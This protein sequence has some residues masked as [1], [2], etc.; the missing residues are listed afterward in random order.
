MLPGSA[1]ASDDV[2]SPLVLHQPNLMPQLLPDTARR[3]WH[4]G[5]IDRMVSDPYR[6]LPDRPPLRD[7]YRTRL[8]TALHRLATLQTHI[9]RLD[10]HCGTLSGAASGGSTAH[11]ER[12]RLH[13]EERIRG[14][15]ACAEKVARV[16]HRLKD[17][18]ESE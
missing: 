1:C 8:R 14:L 16:L 6:A 9:D 5:S 4:P 12:D 10:E 18:P 17:R 2:R 7:A 13:L 3:L 15:R 11:R